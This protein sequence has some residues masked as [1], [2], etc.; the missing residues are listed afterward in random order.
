MIG[1][2]LRRREHEQAVQFWAERSP[3]VYG[4]AFLRTLLLSSPLAIFA[5]RVFIVGAI[6]AAVVLLISGMLFRLELTST[7]MRLRTAI[8]VPTI[9][10]PLAF[11]RRVHV[12]DVRTSRFDGRQ[13]GTLLLNLADGE[14]LSIVGILDPDETAAAI[15]TLAAATLEEARVFR[16]EALER[17]R[18][19][20]I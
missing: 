10:M 5:P 6:V 7:H 9:H 17:S 3:D 16:Q 14:A 12:I 11:V 1:P 19:E 2:L 8:F 18:P 20:R 4:E 13:H 15:R